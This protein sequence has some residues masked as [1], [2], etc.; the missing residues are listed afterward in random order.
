MTIVKNHK[1]YI[2][3]GQKIFVER[4]A[5]KPNFVWFWRYGNINE[6]GLAVVEKDMLFSRPRISRL[7]IV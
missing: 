5:E 6:Q 7:Q 3:N 1:E 2:R 4:Y